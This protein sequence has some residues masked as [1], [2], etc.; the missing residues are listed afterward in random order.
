MNTKTVNILNL[1]YKIFFTL[2]V[3]AAPLVFLTDFTRNPFNIQ[4]FTLACSAGALLALWA[5]RVCCEGRVNLVYTSADFWFLAF[6]CIALLSTLVN[7]L[8]SPAAPALQSE[9][10]RRGHILFT[11]ALAGWMAAKFFAPHDGG[12][13]RIFDAAPA[14]A[15]WA[16]AWLL[17]PAFKMEGLFD[18]YALLVWGA[19]VWLCL[20]ALKNGAAAC[21]LLLAAAL[22][23]AVYGI[24]Q[25]LG[26]E[27]FWRI[28]INYQFGGRA[29]STFGNPNFLSSYI[30]LVLP[31]ALLKFLKA[32]GKIFLCFYFAAV[33][34]FAV[35]MAVSA[36]RSSWLGAAFGLA[37]LLLFKD[38]RALLAAS[39]KRAAV[40]FICAV[41]AFAAW[42]ARRAEAGGGW[43]S[44]FAERAAQSGLRH[45]GLGAP[46]DGLNQA[47]HQRLMMWTCAADIV[48]NKPLG[49]GWGAFQLAYAPCQGRLLAQYPPLHALRTQ[50]NAA[51][52]EL[53]EVLAQ[54]GIIGLFCYIGFF[55]ALVLGFRRRLA[56]LQ[57]AARVFYAAL[58]CGC[59]AM[60]ADNMFNITLQTSVTAFAFWFVLSTVNNSFARRRALQIPRAGA[61][62]LL[63][64]CIALACGVC[65]WQY[66]KIRADVWDF[67]TVKLSGEGDYAGA[68]AAGAKSV[69]AANRSAEAYYTLIAALG[70]RG[71][72]RAQAA[73]AGE[74]AKYNPHYHEFYFRAAA[75]QAALG[76]ND[77]AADNLAAAL[78]LY[79]SYYPAASGLARLMA[80]GAGA[81]ARNFET[82]E[83]A[84]RLMPYA[85]EARL[86]LARAYENAGRGDAAAAAAYAV[87]AADNLDLAAAEY[88]GHFKNSG[89]DIAALLK[90]A[91]AA[92]ELKKLLS[93]AP[94]P[95]SAR[96]KVEAYY[97]ANEG[98]LTAAMLLAEYYFR[99]GNAA[100]A[101]Q[102]LQEV[103]PRNSSDTAL[104]FALSSALAAL[105]RRDE[106]AACLN[107]I[108]RINPF[109]NLAA[110]RLA[111]LR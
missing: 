41:L 103:Y 78:K 58:F 105:G 60:L 98:D 64:L 80:V 96:A 43:Q 95:E 47:W 53:F 14:L 19:G 13:K 72:T 3:F 30:A 74:A 26:Y 5:A 8:T 2:C 81:T 33:I 44:A 18:V 106:A 79:P 101:A 67:K 7:I 37:I 75:A 94:L 63:A 88:L 6:I 25:N 35:Y 23:A 89:A 48:K 104:N 61:A 15:L 65:A 70:R 54:S 57:P 87:L 71:D 111:A 91:A 10:L 73:V 102:L 45:L 93:S 107:N 39:K 85:G 1:L 49:A 56:D 46:A 28:N 83:T 11:N 69:N 92:R 4:T 36:A 38:W 109:N 77:A 40:I 66:F 51:H 82:L 90:K 21:D 86:N 27:I 16:L 100:R 12:D 31:L 9:F 55:A 34:I 110:E 17:F 52:N 68:A 42:P 22:L 97:H 99:T 20:K 59:A 29:I 108:L 62:V 50:A 24:M 32:R 76:D 84:L